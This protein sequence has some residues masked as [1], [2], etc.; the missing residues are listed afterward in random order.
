MARKYLIAHLAHVEIITPKLEESAHFFRELIGMEESGR[1]GH[2]V[3]L[4][5]WDEFY[6]HS[7]VLTEGSQ[8]ALGHI[9][10]RTNG[11]K[12]LEAGELPYLYLRE[13]GG[14]RVELNAHGGYRNYIPDWE[15]VKWVPS[16]GSQTM[17]R[18]IGMPDS[19]GESFPPAPAASFPEPMAMSGRSISTDI[20][21]Q[22]PYGKRVQS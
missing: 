21:L 7:L 20:S 4:R 14:M 8:P 22:N 12:E 19:M 18:N 16:Q 3:Y 5:C 1:Q 15:P 11:Q 6:H 9:G 2:S 10:W 13:P 17:Y